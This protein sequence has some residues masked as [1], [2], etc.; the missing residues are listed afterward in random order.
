[1]IKYSLLLFFALISEGVWAQCAGQIME[2][3]F[4]FVTSSRGCAPFNLQLQ[5]RY[6][7]STPGTIYY[8]N[9]GDGSAQQTYTQTA[10]F[11][12]GPI[13]SHVYPNAA[14]NCFY[15]ITIEVENACNP[16]GSVVLEPIFITVWTNDIISINPS[17]FRV[18]QG[19]A[20]SLNFTDNS[21]WNCFPHP[22]PVRENNEGRWIQWIYG[23]GNAANQIPGMRI[24]NII[25]NA[26]P[27]KDPA[28]GKNPIYPVAAPGQLSLPVNVPVTL[29]VDIGK[30]FQVTLK[31]W[32]QCNPYDNVLNDGNAF[33]PVNGDLVDGDNIPQV[34]TARIVIVDTPKPN[35]VTRL[36][37]AA[38]PI[39]SVFCA[40]DA[41]FFDNETPA[42]AGAAFDYTWEFFDNNTGT[43][44]PLAT[45]TTTNPIFTYIATGQKL[46]R[47]KVHDNNAAGNCEAIYESVITISPSLIAKIAVTDLSGNAITPDFCQENAAPLTTFVAR[48][49]DVSVGAII[50]STRWR[51]EFYDN[52]NTLIF[53]SPAAGEFSNTQPGP[54]DRTFIAPGVYKV[55]LRIRD[56][57]TSCETSDEVQ[58]SVFRK[59]QAD[60]IFSTA[61]QGNP[62]AFTDLSTLNAVSGEQIALREWDMN[63]DGVTFSKDPALDNQTSFDYVFPTRGTFKVALRVTTNGGGCSSLIEREVTVDPLPNASFTAD[64]ISGCSELQVEFTNHSL[65][66]QPDVIK[67]YRWEIDRGSG[68]QVDSI[69]HPSDPDF[70]DVFVKNF[71][72]MGSA[73]ASYFVRL[74]V[75]TVND[76][77]RVS[78]PVNIIVF[79]TPRAGFVSVNYSPFNTN[80][81]PVSVSFSVD[82]QTQS[83]NP[84]DY[85][86]TVADSDGMLAQISTGTTP[87]FTYDFVNATESLKDFFVTLRANLPSGCYG[88]STRMIRVSPVPG[89]AF[90]IDT[91]SYMCD[92]VVL[93]FDAIQK[94]LQ[95]YNWTIIS[96]GITLFNSASVRDQFDYEIMRS[97]SVDQQIEIKLFTTNLANC[98]SGVTSQ[99]VT[100]KKASVINAAFTVSPVR[101]KFPDAT[102]IITNTTNPGPWQYHWNFGDGTT[103]TATTVNNHIYQTP[104]VFTITL[105]VS[106][107]DCIETKTATIQIDPAPPVLDFEYNPASGC[108]P[109]TVNFTNKSKYADPA[110]YAWQFGANQG[111]SHATNPSYTY[112]EPGIYSVTLS[113]SNSAGEI[114]NITKQLIIEVYDKPAAR[115]DVK[116]RQIQFPGGKLYTDNQSFDATSYY[117]DFGDGTSSTDFEPQH[118]YTYEGVF[119]ISLIASNVERCADTTKIDAGVQTIRSGQ[120]LVPNAF[121]PNLSGPGNSQGQNDT[122]RPMLQGVTDFEMLVFNRWGQLLF[123][124]KNPEFGW[125]GYYQGK[126]CQQDV[127]IY[128]IIAKYSNGETITRVGDI[129][130][131]R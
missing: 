26:F 6:L 75:V 78:A 34:T 70:S 12:N 48:F 58:L 105:T 84:T 18:C 47:L 101:Q 82:N 51:W 71:I 126:L 20:A 3:G 122:F 93:D 60:F 114:S 99:T 61:C 30:E 117:W 19:Y 64:K 43:G 72:N 91:I 87:E 111:T 44:A 42:I 55:K 41:I 32:N 130:L 102:V 56:N 119:T 9:W 109:L 73:D 110:T 49:N 95:Q 5:T 24:N 116:P 124:T 50:S 103:S 100:V 27:Y 63:Y 2:P 57:L 38:G 21:D 98:K 31:N 65:I 4:N 35:Y 115:F 59:P 106:N 25:P 128:K 88:D 96:N 107:R 77:E 104:G 85:L 1:V 13:V 40:G 81:S 113:A 33:N 121:S 8:V 94:G 125:D 74:R 16:R 29:P 67:E 22:N 79:P 17:V 66:S 90:T 112:Y 23:T 52:S 53:Q 92:R 15:Q 10:S 7:Q 36:G 97:L 54:F 45:R 62:I 14:Q 46:I 86:W 108:V 69:Q 120:L 131:M 129:H 127:Y 123:E 28:P 118:V 11:P 80:C 83:Y 89:S 39:Q 76:C 68:F 37:N